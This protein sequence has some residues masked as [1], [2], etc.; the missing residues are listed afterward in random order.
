MVADG[1]TEQQRATLAALQ[2]G[3]IAGYL[4][5]YANGST[6]LLNATDLGHVMQTAQRHHAHPVPLIVGHEPGARAG[7]NHGPTV[8]ENGCHCLPTL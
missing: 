4:L 6:G 8:T 3:Q 5:I 7:A 1:L 2:P